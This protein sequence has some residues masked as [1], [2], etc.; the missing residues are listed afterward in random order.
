M[1]YN[2]VI[3]KLPYP[4]SISFPFPSL[5]SYLLKSSSLSLFMLSGHQRPSL[6]G[7]KE[8][9]LIE[10]TKRNRRTSL[11][12]TWDQIRMGAETNRKGSLYG[13]QKWL[14]CRAVTTGVSGSSLAGLFSGIPDSA[15]ECPSA[16]F[17]TQP[18]F[19]LGIG[20]QGGTGWGL[21]S[22]CLWEKEDIWPSNKFHH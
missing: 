17:S 6:G 22:R 1:W 8:W 2:F 9:E 4:G 14:L 12:E 5:F 11:A 20:L 15:I 18:S 13:T 10:K 16:Y 19:S 3:R 7:P 21:R